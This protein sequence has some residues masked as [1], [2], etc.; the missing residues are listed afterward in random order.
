MRTSWFLRL[1][2]ILILLSVAGSRTFSQNAPPTPNAIRNVHDPCIIKDGDFYYVFSTGAGIPIRRSRDLVHWE[3]IGRVFADAVPAWATKEIPG[4]T[5]LWAPDI[6]RHGKE[7]RLY[8]SVSTFGKNHS[9][10]ALATNKTLD[11]SSKDYAWHDAGKVWES[12]PTD[13]YN[14]ID[15]NAVVVKEKNGLALAFGSFWS[16]IKLIRLDPQTGKPLANAAVESIASR[17]RFGA[18]EAPFIVR[19]GDYYYQF[20][21]FDAC[22]KGVDSTYNIRIGRSKTVDGP[23]RD[24]EGKSLM[25]GGGTSVLA[26]TGRFIGPGHC[27]VL[28]DGKKD[29]LVNHFYDG[30]AN[31]VPTLQIRPIHW[32]KDGWLNVAQPLTP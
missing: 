22:C 1:T 18:I 14:A 7:F 12:F 29:Y 11:P 27:A 24:K 8:Y 31:G 25:D 30:D 15:P 23:Y 5:S 32:D 3:R 28:H 20:I 6:S 10:I 2:I 16:G 19:H 26:T 13:D 17:A 21:S 9:L 4:S